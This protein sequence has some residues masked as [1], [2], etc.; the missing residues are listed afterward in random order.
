MQRNA[1]WTDTTVL[2]SRLSWRL[3]SRRNLKAGVRK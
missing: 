1:D 2:D 3:L